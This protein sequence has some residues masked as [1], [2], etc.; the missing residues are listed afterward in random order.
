MPNATWDD[1]THALPP[2]GRFEFVGLPTD[3]FSIH[4]AVKGYHLSRENPNLS[5]G[6]DGFIDR[7][8]DNFVILLDP[9]KEN[10]SRMGKDFRGKPL[11]SAPQP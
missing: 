4:P 5:H 1:Q 2:D 11:R 6:I 9:G 3:D 7:D 8:V 10:F